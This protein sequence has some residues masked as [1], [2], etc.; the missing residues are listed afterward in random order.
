MS[1]AATKTCGKCGEVKSLVMMLKKGNSCKAC[2]AAYSKAWYEA[3]RKTRIAKSTDWKKANPDSVRE[4]QKK[5]HAANQEKKRAY[6]KARH[7]A[8]REDDNARA[9]RWREE[10][11][12]A[13]ASWKADQRKAL[14]SYYVK[15]LIS[16]RT[17]LPPSRIQI[18]LIEVKRKHLQILRKIK[19]LTNE[20]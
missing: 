7:T 20:R 8:N 10:H 11:P 3:N 18:E 17:G 5:Y 9:R 2:A 4:Y 12:T 15:R 14:S 6:A 16:E 1:D 19:E 13:L